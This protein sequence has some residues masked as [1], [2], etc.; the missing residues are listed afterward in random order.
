MHRTFF[1]LLFIFCIPGMLFSQTLSGTITDFKT[2][3]AMIGATVVIKGTTLGTTTDL[4]GKFSLDI[5]RQPPFTIM[6]SLVGYQ[7]QE[8]EVTQLEKPLVIR[9]KSSEVELKNVDVVGSRISEK[10]KEAP[11]TVESIDMISIKECPQSSFYESLGSLKGVD[12]TSASLGFTIINTRGFNSTSPVRSLQLIDGVDNQSPGL[13]FSLGNFLGC[14]ELD[15]LKVDLIAGAS[16]SY[17]G[18]GAFNGVISMTTRSPFVKPG[19]EV[20][21][22]VGERNLYEQA[23]RVAQVFKNK[24]GRD[25]I[26]VKFNLYYMKALDWEANNEDPTAQSQHDQRNPGGYDAVNRYGDEN[27]SSGDFSSVPLTYPGLGV[28]Y[29][30]GYWEKDIVDYHTQNLKLGTAVHIKVTPDVELIFASSFGTGT[31]VYQ[32]D[33]RYSLKDISFYQNRVEI[34]KQDK[35]FLRAYSTNEDAGKSYDAFFTA[36]LLQRESKS[37]E[38]WLRDYSRYWFLKFK[39]KILSYPD[40][41]QQSDYLNFTDYKNAI[42]PYLLEHYYDSLIQYHA[43]ARAWA[44]SIGYSSDNHAFFA[45]GTNAFDTALASITSRT[46]YAEGGSRFYD[47]SAL[48]HIAGEYKFTPKISDIIIGGS[49]RM[50]RPN[51]NGSIFSDTGATTIKNNEF[52][53]YA[54]LEKK[55]LREK[56]KVNIT[57]R[58]DKNENFDY[59]ISPA[60]SAVYSFSPQQIFRASFSSAIRNPTLTDQYLFYNV[61]RATLKGNLDGFDSLV[62]IPSVFTFFNTQKFDSLQ[63]FNVAPVKPEEVKTVEVGYRGTILKNIFI[64]LVGYYSW[65]KNFIGYKIG[66]DITELPQFAQISINEIYRVATNSID[67]VTTRGVSIGINYYFRKYFMLNGN[68]SYNK[69]DRGASTDPL[70]PAFNTPENKYNLGFSARDLKNFGFNVNYK[71][72]QGFDYEGSPQFTGYVPSYNMVD[73]QVNY[74]IQNI[75]STLKLGAS[76]LFNNKKF[77]VYGGPRVGRMAYVSIVVDLTR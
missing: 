66:A 5:S 68:Y 56:L 73:A 13:N 32:G 59:L 30:S 41:P 46:S 67:E 24:K 34:R 7:K 26:G 61:G 20:M 54:G 60:L 2:G 28:W 35:F 9:M 27:Y 63:Y 12:L 62:T 22:K 29:R 75:H 14:G 49:Y 23:F 42:N 51:S 43:D 40:F 11:L 72:V 77:T 45:P 19:L 10:Q 3:E 25:F 6:I 53:I 4:D 44:D 17:F 55:I 36:L 47:K 15:V 1:A 8:L 52:G 64:D 50:Y 37:D 21:F 16:T 33:N 70:I 39:N 71:W 38:D 57:G 48:Y 18:P 65:Y 76:N 74:K 31:T 58:L 69:L